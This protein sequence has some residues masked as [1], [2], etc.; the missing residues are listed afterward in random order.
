MRMMAKNLET[1]KTGWPIPTKV[2]ESF[3][4]FAAHIGAIAQED[5]AGALFLWQHMPAQIREW[6]KLD[7]KGSPVVDSDFWKGL[8][9]GLELSLRAHSEVQ[10]Q[11][12]GKKGAES[13]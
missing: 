2:K 13:G 3:V 9:V 6:A 4:E 7:A 10:K 11:R 12:K 1:T 8:N 5:C